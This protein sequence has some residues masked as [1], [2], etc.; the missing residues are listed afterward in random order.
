MGIFDVFKKKEKSIPAED[1]KVKPII[2]AY[3]NNTD[4]DLVEEFKKENAKDLAVIK[5]AGIKIVVKE[6]DN[7]P[8]V[9]SNTTPLPPDF[10]I[11]EFKIHDDIK[12]LLWFGDGK[13]KNLTK[14]QMAK[15]KDVFTLTWTV[16]LSIDEPSLIYMSEQIIKPQDESVIPRPPY[17]PKYKQLTPEQKWVYLKLLTNPYNTEIDIGYIFILYYGL[18]RHLL[19]GDFDSAFKVILKLRDVHKNKSFQNYSGNAL[20]LSALFHGKGEYIPLFIDSLDKDYEFGFSDN[21][22]LMS[23][24]S[25]NV[26]WLPKDVM[27]MAKTF[28]FTNTNYIKKN[29]D[30]FLNNLSDIIKEKTGQ[31]SIDLKK[32]ITA[33]ELRKIKREQTTIFCNS[34]IIGNTVP[35]PLLSEN[36]NLKK[37]INLILEA[38]HER[39]KSKVAEIKK[40]KKYGFY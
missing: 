36:F 27:R 9:I 4:D 11:N 7:S 1:L 32:Y 12:N 40:G 24:Y 17:F 19:Q 31:E 6:I 33:S 23:Y 21:L 14:E 29:P 30:L 20:I 25:F 10:Y 15:D 22:F 13:Y 2:N 38:T 8:K 39:T 35:I 18:E 37:E 26:P 16:G 5:N 34:S 3:K 28:E